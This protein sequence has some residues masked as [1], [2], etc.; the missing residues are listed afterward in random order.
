MRSVL[1]QEISPALI[2]DMGATTTKLY[3]VE[4]GILRSSH[5]INRGSQNITNEL[6]KSLGISLEDAE[7]LKREKGIP[8]SINGIEVREVMTITLN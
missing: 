2:I 7:Y 8:G 4:K 5:M 6:S 3:I 1:D